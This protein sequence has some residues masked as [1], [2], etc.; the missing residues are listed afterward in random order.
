MVSC[1]NEIGGEG[2]IAANLRPQVFHPLGR[3]S[4]SRVMQSGQRLE[5]F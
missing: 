4:Q 3:I 2:G 1:Q 5:G